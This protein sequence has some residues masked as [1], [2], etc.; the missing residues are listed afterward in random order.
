MSASTNVKRGGWRNWLIPPLARSLRLLG[1]E[2]R[3]WWTLPFPYHPLIAFLLP[4]VPVGLA[5]WAAFRLVEGRPSPISGFGFV[6][7]ALLL[8]IPL[9]IPIL[10]VVAIAFRVHLLQGLCFLAGMAVLGA[11]VLNGSRPAAW[12]ALPAAFFALF[13]IQRIGGPR[14]L[15]RLQADNAAFVPVQAGERLVRYRSSAPAAARA[16][17]AQQLFEKFGLAWLAFKPA[18]RRSR[19]QILFRPSDSAAGVLRTLLEPGEWRAGKGGLSLDD[20]D[21]PTVADSVTISVR[22]KGSWLLTGPLR[23]VT[24]QSGSRRRRLSAG[25]PAPVGNWPLLVL[26]YDFAIFSGAAR[27]PS[28]YA[29]F[30]PGRPVALGDRPAGELVEASLV[31]SNPS[32]EISAEALTGLLDLILPDLVLRRAREAEQK[33]WQIEKASADLEP[34]LSGEAKSAFLAHWRLLLDRPATLSGRGRELCARLAESKAARDRRSAEIAASLLAALPLEEFVELE[35]EL[36]PL[37]GSRILA[38]EWQLTPGLDVSKLPKDCPRWGPIAGFGLMSRVPELWA[39]LGE[40]GPRGE[41]I[42]AVFIEEVGERPMLASARIRYVER[43][44]GR[45]P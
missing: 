35:D 32:A 5:G 29:G 17:Q 19:W 20:V 10:N 36:I 12:G 42:A 41:K 3:F 2:I 23:T 28:W 11:E 38:L 33:E 1:F 40:L 44:S 9:S 15:S 27:K 6:A 43:K 30:V 13:A 22:E 31:A 21:L 25:R 39:R 4:F 37:L 8:V 26:A 16:R 18:R 34:W 7:A 24:V 14:L 45:K